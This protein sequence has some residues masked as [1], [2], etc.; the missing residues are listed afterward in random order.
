M[1]PRSQTTLEPASQTPTRLD[2]HELSVDPSHTF[3]DGCLDRFAAP[4]VCWR[5]SGWSRLRRRV[6]QTLLRSTLSESRLDRFTRCGSNA[7]IYLDKADPPRPHMRADYC[8]DR[9]CRPCSSARAVRIREMLQPYLTRPGLRFVT[10]TL[11]HCDDPLKSQLRYLTACF[12]RLRQTAFWKKAT[13]GGVAFMEV[14]RSKDGA[15]WHP[16][17]HCIVEGAYLPKGLLSDAWRK[18]TGHSYIVDVSL[19]RTQEHALR[20][21]TK[22]VTKPISVNTFNV[23]DTAVEATQALVGTRTMTLFGQWHGLRLPK[24]AY[25]DDLEPFAPF[26]FVWNNRGSTRPVYKTIIQRL[27]DERQGRSPPQPRG[28]ATTTGLVPGD[29][30]S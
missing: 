29:F 23:L 20:Y 1:N 22:Y 5:H 24:P 12:R 7:W 8:R 6:W 4:D 28:K 19:I 3:T 2:H 25:S 30:E 21:V 13:K 27:E 11:R 17:L 26:N 14:K 18:A 9:L 16:H 10:L 15:H